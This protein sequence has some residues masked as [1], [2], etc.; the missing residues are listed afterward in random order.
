MQKY[1]VRADSPRARSSSLGE[2]EDVQKRKRGDEDLGKSEELRAFKKSTILPRSP[3]KETKQVNMDAILK[4]LEVLDVIREE[5]SEIKENNKTLRNELSE[6]Q[7]KIETENLYL[8]SKVKELEEKVVTLEKREEKRERH[9]RRNN[10]IITGILQDRAKRD[11]ELLKKNVQ[12]ICKNITGEDIEIEDV[13]VVATRTSGE[14]IVKAKIKTFDKKKKIM[15]NKHKLKT[16]KKKIFIEDDL[17]VEERKVQGILRTR[18][19]EEKNK[20]N[21]AKVGY[22]KIKIND[23]WIRWEENQEFK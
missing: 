12:D 18:A 6:Y 19:K 5:L 23:K 1:L 16:L 20:G 11:P 8:S 10:I 3:R 15:K 21:T 7:K 13:F 4:K 22:R 14:N 2:I 9:E 17:T